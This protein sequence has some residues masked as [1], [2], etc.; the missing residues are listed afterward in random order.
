M[1]EYVYTSISHTI[2]FLSYRNH[3]PNRN[4]DTS[5]DQYSNEAANTMASIDEYYRV[6]DACAKAEMKVDFELQYK[7]TRKS[8]NAA[9]TSVDKRQYNRNY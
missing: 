5:Y 3:M 9:S 2:S 7:S 1:L 8:L 6:A 4:M